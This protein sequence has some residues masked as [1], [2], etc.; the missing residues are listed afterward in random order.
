[1]NA[2][3]FCRRFSTKPYANLLPQNQV[4]ANLMTYLQPT[5]PGAIQLEPSGCS[6]QGSAR[7]QRLTRWRTVKM[8]S[9]RMPSSSVRHR[10]V[11]R[12]LAFIGQNFHRPIGLPEVVKISGMSRRGLLKAFNRHL[13]MAPAS[14]LRHVRLEH[15]KRLLMEHDI[16][17]CDLARRCGYRSVNSFCVA[18]HRQMRLA[19]KQYQRR[20]LLAVFQGIARAGQDRLSL[21]AKCV[22][23]AAPATTLSRTGFSNQTNLATQCTSKL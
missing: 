6:E 8:R 23:V 17:L 3:I 14:Y 7:R 9:I 18:F 4:S 20:Y 1:M 22:K 2:G 11:N 13:G 12:S 15:A 16:R 21:V 5:D 10:G 19:P